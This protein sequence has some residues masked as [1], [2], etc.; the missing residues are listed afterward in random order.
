MVEG[1]CRIPGVPPE[2]LDQCRQDIELSDGAE[3]P[4]DPSKT[5]LGRPSGLVIGFEEREP[6][7]KAARSDSVRCSASTLPCSTPGRTRLNVS[8]CLRKAVC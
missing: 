7:A 5:A 4:G 8:S 3:M 6:L 2:A 1:Q